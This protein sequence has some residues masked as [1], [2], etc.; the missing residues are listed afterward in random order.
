MDLPAL[1]YSIMLNGVTQL[2]MMKVD[3]LN[4][5]DEIKICT[6]YQLPDGTTTEEFP[7]DICD[8]EVTPVYKTFKGWNSS[9]ENITDFEKMPEEL[10]T[11]T[12]YIEKEVGV[13]VTYVSTGPD[14][15]AT[16]TRA[17]GL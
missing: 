12:A 17:S 5:F 3:V 10:K 8:V 16:L 2:V 9:L 1:K 4:I 15:T 6:H 13:P 14:R 11:Y 7:Y